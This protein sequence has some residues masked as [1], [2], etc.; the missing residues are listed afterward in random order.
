MYLD[1]LQLIRRGGVGMLEGFSGGQDEEADAGGTQGAGD[2]RLGAGD[3]RRQQVV[4]PDGRGDPHQ[5]P[6]R[7]REGSSTRSRRTSRRSRGSPSVKAA[8]L[9]D[10]VLGN[11]PGKEVGKAIGDILMTL[12]MPAVPQGPEC[13]RPRRADRTQPPRR[14]RPGRVP[15]R[16]RPLPRQARRPRAQIPRRGAGR[17]LHRQAAPVPLGGEGLP[18]LQ[19]RRNGKDDD[20]R[21]TDDVPAGDDPRVRMPLPPLRRDR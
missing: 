7:T 17:P 9:A 1:S 15:C 13:A 19:L 11:D 12:L 3:R 21:W 8:L 20:G 14:L 6:R 5:G 4:R 10:V 16:H 18:L 2:D